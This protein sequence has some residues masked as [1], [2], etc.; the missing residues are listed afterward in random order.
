MGRAAVKQCKASGLVRQLYGCDF[1][2]TAQGGVQEPHIATG[3]SDNNVSRGSSSIC[4]DGSGG[5]LPF[6]Q[7]QETGGINASD[8]TSCNLGQGDQC[9]AERLTGQDCLRNSWGAK[10]MHAGNHYGSRGT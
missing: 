6:V 7:Q 5:R 1:L 8:G 4:N 3:S 9:T 10:S 2:K